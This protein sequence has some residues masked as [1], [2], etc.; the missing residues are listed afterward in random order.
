[1]AMEFEINGFGEN[2]R[3]LCVFITSSFRR[4]VLSVAVRRVWP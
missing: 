3:L 1:M 2:P 4:D